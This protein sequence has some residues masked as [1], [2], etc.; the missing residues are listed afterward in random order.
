MGIDVMVPPVM[1]GWL[2]WNW[3]DEFAESVA[4]ML[5]GFISW[6]AY[7]VNRTIEH[8]FTFSDIAADQNRGLWAALVGGEIQYQNP[9]SGETLAAV[10]HPGV[11]NL[12]VGA[13]I[14]FF[15]MFV[16]F[17]I[18]TAL[19][20]KSSAGFLRACV[21]MITGI[22]L[23]YIAAGMTWAAMAATSNLSQYIIGISEDAT[24]ESPEQASPARAILAMMGFYVVDDPPAGHQAALETPDGGVL[25]MDERAEHLGQLSSA[26]ADFEF[27]VGHLGTAVGVGAICL[28]FFLA[29]IFLILMMVF[30]ML[31]L[32][33]LATF[34][35][36]AIMGLTWDAA[37]PVATKWLQVTMALLIAEPAAAVIIQ[38]G[39]TMSM[40][41]N[42]WIQ[43]AMGLAVIVVAGCMPV[44]MM[45]LMNFMTGG[46]GEGIDRAGIAVAA[47]GLG[48]A[49]AAGWKTVRGVGGAGL[50]ALRRPL[51]R[52]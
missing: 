29:A 41:A 38:L 34:V 22:P 25:L 31:A 4:M 51:G 17:Q 50:R 44:V 20:R 48:V 52:K 16:A 33:I 32:L 15:A 5:F 9:D 19:V 18:I 6:A 37:K 43:V 23:V 2:P 46:A 39:S 11:L 36:V 10:S 47:G 14:P 27:T 1:W 26:G 8:A 24:G 3:G 49:G 28:V 21:M 12:V 30:R 13:M 7:G 35:P 40:F 45:S 42:S